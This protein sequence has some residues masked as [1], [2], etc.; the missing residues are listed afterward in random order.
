M[1]THRTRAIA[2]DRNLTRWSRLATH[3][4]RSGFILLALTQTGCGQLSAKPGES[5]YVQLGG[6]AI[7]EAVVSDMVDTVVADP[8]VNQ[9][10]KQVRLTRF[11][12]HLHAFVCNIADGPCEYKGDPIPLVHAGLRI[13]EKE[14]NTVVQALRDAL[15]RHG[16]GES[17]KNELLRRLA[18]L[19]RDIVTA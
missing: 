3:R 6:T 19:K 1:L 5:L 11:K 15:H 8:Q 12:K 4:L 9:S 13:T 17:A 7:M 16:V 10:F 2:S 14:F 18:P